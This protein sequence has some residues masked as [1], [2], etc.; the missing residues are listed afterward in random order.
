MHVKA[1]PDF[2]DLDR[3][4]HASR[5]TLQAWGLGL[6][7]ALPAAFAARY[8]ISEFAV[9]TFSVSVIVLLRTHSRTRRREARVDVLASG[10]GL[11]W[12][13]LC[14]FVPGGHVFVYAAPA[15]V[16]LVVSVAHGRV[17]H[18]RA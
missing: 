3:M 18:A 10:A 13:I 17:R 14:L 11:G 2:A 1:G 12:T 6:A 16:A 15:V 4:W 8:R 7:I 9:L 5:V